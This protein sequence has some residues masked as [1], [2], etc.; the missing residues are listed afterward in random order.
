M[1]RRHL[2]IVQ[3]AGGSGAPAGGDS[4]PPDA[5]FDELL[6]VMTGDDDRVELIRPPA[7]QPGPGAQQGGVPIGWSAKPDPSARHV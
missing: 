6:T 4:D 1:D 5:V 3:E 2:T 7:A